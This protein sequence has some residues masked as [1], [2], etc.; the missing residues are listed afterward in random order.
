MK[1]QFVIFVSLLAIPAL[2][3]YAQY[4][5]PEDYIRSLK[6]NIQTYGPAETV[7]NDFCLQ[8]KKNINALFTHDEP[9]NI[10]N[11]SYEMNETSLKVYYNLQSFDHTTKCRLLWCVANSK[12]ASLFPDAIEDSI[13]ALVYIPAAI[14]AFDRY[15]SDENTAFGVWA[16][17]YLPAARYGIIADSC[18]DERL[19]P[20]KASKASG[21]YLN[22]LHQSFGSWDYAVTAYVCGPAKLR[23]AMI[24][25]KNFEETLNNLEPKYRNSFYILLAIIRWMEENETEMLTFPFMPEVEAVDNIIIEDRVHFAQIAEVMQIDLN[26]LMGLNPYYTGKVIDGRFF[27]KTIYLPHGTKEQFLSIK[28]SI[29]NFKDSIYFAAYKPLQIT[30]DR[31]YYSYESS[32]SENKSPGE[33]FEEIRHKIVSGDNLSHLA[34]KYKVKISDLQEWNNISGENIY[35]GNTLSIWVKKGT[36]SNYTKPKTEVKQNNTETT[37]P[38]QTNKE[39]SAAKKSFSAKDYT[40]VDT[41]IVKSGDSLYKISLSYSWTTPEDIM[42]WNNISDPS[43][44]QIGQ[45][46]KIYKKK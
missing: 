16:L 17:H 2:S 22:Y 31:T 4:V 46:L 32:A 26:Q 36:A 7:L 44:L 25:T 14:A 20:Q 23:K 28:D 37:K 9:V 35:I 1:K 42:L 15:Y 45:K 39:Q 19:N 40:I 5:E 12:Y 34:E 3:V 38:A 43:L 8:Y 41:Y 21:Q 18:Y 33:D 10:G 29:L 13:S 11:E 6:T 30:D 27:A 24:G